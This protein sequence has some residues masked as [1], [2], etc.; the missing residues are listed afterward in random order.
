M[1]SFTNYETKKIEYVNPKFFKTFGL[2]RG[3][4]MNDE[5]YASPAGR[6]TV[7]EKKAHEYVPGRKPIDKTIHKFENDDIP[8]WQKTSLFPF[9]ENGVVTHTLGIIEDIS[10]EMRDAE[11]LRIAK[12]NYE[13]IAQNVPNAI[14]I[15]SKEGHQLYANKKASEL[16]GYSN[17]EILNLN[18][19]DLIHPDDLVKVN[20][21]LVA[22][23]K[24]EFLEQGY[25]ARI[26]TK[27]GDTRIVLVSG[28]KSKWMGDLVDL[29][30]L[31]DI[32]DQRRFEGLLKIQ[33]KIDYLSSIP[34][35]LEKSLNNIFDSLFEFNWI[36]GGGVY[37]M[38]NDQNELQLVF[39]KGLSKRFIK[40]YQ[41]LPQG[42]DQYS[43]MMSEKCS[44]YRS[45]KSFPETKFLKEEG[46]KELLII[47]LLHDDKIIGALNL[48]TRGKIALTINERMIFESIGTRI[49][50]MIT[51]ILIQDKLTI[52]NEELQRTLKDKQEKKQL[53]IQK[54]KLESLGE[55]AAGVAHE[56]NQPLGVILLSLENILFKIS[57]KKA[58]REYLDLKFTSIFNNIE[59]IKTIIDHIRTFSHDQKSIIIERINVNEVISNA[60]SLINEQYA[61]H[62]ISLNLSLDEDLGY[63]LGNN[64]KMEQVIFNLL[65]NARFALEEKDATSLPEPFE[66][67]INIRTYSDDKKI[68]ID[69][70][71]NGTGIEKNDLQNI[72]NPFFTTKPEGVGTGL[73]LSIVYGI[74]TEMRGA[75]AIESKKNEFTLARIE[76]SRY[77]IKN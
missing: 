7:V 16:T 53:L 29:V 17:S 49:A 42:S 65:S 68:Y 76:L 74:I 35:G 20:A 14:F 51:L 22:R 5:L 41:V 75:I 6:L 32:T 52:R 25:E 70:R 9:V 38:D 48:A 45:M 39:H 71:D 11:D 40:R 57:A 47:P 61:Y 44:Y 30:V 69:V 10:N 33:D 58:S 37:V 36:D 23:L 50:Q 3:D 1:I 60:C 66:K 31:S 24:G 4:V 28:A 63:A 77:R 34:V 73:G 19:I 13:H 67:E 27:K 18:L 64:Q 54:S 56:I 21:R 59:K 72:F 12:E 46:L 2:R 26:I 55:M 8:V 62:N 43:A 15:G